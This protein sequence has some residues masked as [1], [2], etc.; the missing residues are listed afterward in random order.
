MHNKTL[1]LKDILKNMATVIFLLLT[2][3]YSSLCLAQE[4]KVENNAK[5][6]SDIAEIDQPTK[7]IKKSHAISVFGDLKYSENFKHFDYVNPEAVRGGAVTQYGIG[8]FDSLNPFIMKGVP[9]GGMEMIF[10]SL[11]K[12][13]YDEV[14]TSYGLLAK[15]VEIDPDN[16]WVTF[17]IRDIAKWHDGSKISADDVVFSFNI[18]KKQGHPK[19]KS[20][21]RDVVK[22]EKI[23]DN[24]V[25]F[26]FQN[27]EN[28]ELP[29]IIGQLPIAS[30]KY[31]SKVEFNKTTMTAPL[32][33]GPYKMKN[34]DAGRSIT[35]ERVEDYWAKD[36]PVNI[37]YYNFDELK[38]D[39]YRDSTIAVE[40]FKAGEYD[41][42]KENISKVWKKSYNIPQIEDGRI[43]KE[44]LPDGMPSGM[45]CFVFNT[46]LAKFSNRNV[47]KALQLAYNFEWANEQLF[48]GAYKRNR[49]FFGNSKLEAKGL[50]SE[51]ELELLTPFRGI[52]PDEVFTTEYQPPFTPDIK[53]HRNLLLEAQNI[54]DQEGY[55]LKDMKRIDPST[56]RQM[57]IE[58][59]IVSPLFE[60]IVAPYIRSLKKLGIKA[61]IRS[62]DSSQF[63]KRRDNFDF[64]VIVNWFLQ[65]ATPGNEQIN[66]W[67]SSRADVAGSK[68]Y[69][70]IKNEAV[71][72]MVDKITS[73]NSK[74]ELITAGKA[75][76]RILQWNYYVIPQWYSTTHRLIYWN[77]VERP[78]QT[79][80]YSH[81]FP[82]IWWSKD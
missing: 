77:K 79:P 1:I 45:Q 50:P 21:Y 17:T 49:S 42:R 46:R 32:G 7:P 34:V 78:E 27:S 22:A 33:S 28:K 36:L 4:P 6:Q 2:C 61:N 18:I 47:R 35:F 70:G 59:L 72:F 62:I 9:A 71:D 44:T 3:L 56:N 15:S 26:S 55:V 12:S 68:N 65:S 76:D 52:L 14:A 53:A 57:Q 30:K 39:Y 20:Y 66:Y 5:L 25:K 37:G 82:E 75:L 23:S 24:K 41:F 73:A 8:T 51:E 81:G 38:F 80:P 31:Y 13:S 48:Y 60:R 63:I 10:D 43:I 11:M 64:D 67:H 69:I 16:E 58:F 29:L 19:Y 40:A 74:Q 54:L